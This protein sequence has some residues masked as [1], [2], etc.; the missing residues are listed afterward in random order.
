MV[1]YPDVSLFPAKLNLHPAVS[2][3]LLVSD[4]LPADRL[5]PFYPIMIKVVDWA[6]V[7]SEE[8][9]NS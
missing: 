2:L 5:H 4:S 1:R 3:T 8:V 6:C 7:F 9:G